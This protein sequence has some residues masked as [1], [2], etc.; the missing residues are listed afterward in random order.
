MDDVCSAMVT[1]G[2]SPFDDGQRKNDLA[3]LIAASI[4]RSNNSAL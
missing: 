1:R 2:L 3:K 4:A